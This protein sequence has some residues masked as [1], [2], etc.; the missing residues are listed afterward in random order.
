MK[1]SVAR[2]LSEQEI[3]FCKNWAAA[4]FDTFQRNHCYRLAFPEHAGR[5][6]NEIAKTVARLLERPL[7]KKYLAELKASPVDQARRTLIA[8]LETGSDTAKSRAAEHILANDELLG[9]QDAHLHW[10]RTLCQAGAHVEIPL[11]GACSQCGAPFIVTTT[12]L[13]LFPQW[14]PKEESP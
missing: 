11:P 6:S 3:E 14:K 4:D 10:A 8:Q 12:L 2:I 9:A 13:E 1:P 7:I 5:G